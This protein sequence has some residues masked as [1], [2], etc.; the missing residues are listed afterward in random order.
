MGVIQLI[1]ELD[2][3]VYVWQGV[4]T[5]EEED[6]LM[7]D[8][9]AEDPSIWVLQGADGLWVEAREH[10]VGEHELRFDPNDAFPSYCYCL[11]CGATRI[12]PFKS[13]DEFI[14]ITANNLFY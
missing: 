2:G 10:L 14:R 1:K 11:I 3:G 9:R 5:L 6:Q 8:I 12:S 4:L 13:S 7:A